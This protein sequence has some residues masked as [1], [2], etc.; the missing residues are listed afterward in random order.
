MLSPSTSVVPSQYHFDG[1][2]YYFVYYLVSFS[3]CT[4]GFFPCQHH[5]TSAPTNSSNIDAVYSWQQTVQL[6]KTIKKK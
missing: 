4:S 5:S 1:S 2:I 3:L 6:N